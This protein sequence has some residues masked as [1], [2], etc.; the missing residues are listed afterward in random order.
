MFQSPVECIGFTSGAVVLAWKQEWHCYVYFI[1]HPCPRSTRVRK[2]LT[3]TPPPT[4]CST[5]EARNLLRFQP[6]GVHE[7][8]ALQPPSE[9]TLCKVKKSPLNAPFFVSLP[10]NINCLIFFWMPWMRNCCKWSWTVSVNLWV[11]YET[12]QLNNVKTSDIVNFPLSSFLMQMLVLYSKSI[13]K[14]QLPYMTS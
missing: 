3:P 14:P 12:T 1:F 4:C 10:L 8:S 9:W 6:A 5:N 7:N 11:Q 13:G 2:A